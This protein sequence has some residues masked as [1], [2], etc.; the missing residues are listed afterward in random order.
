VPGRDDDDIS[1]LSSAAEPKHTMI[2]QIDEIDMST[3]TIPKSSVVNAI[4]TACLIDDDNP[5]DF[6]SPRYNVGLSPHDWIYE[7]DDEYDSFDFPQSIQSPILSSDHHQFITDNSTPTTTPRNALLA[8]ED[9]INKLGITKTEFYDNLRNIYPTLTNRASLRAHFDGGSM[10]TTTDQLC[11]LW[12][13]KDLN[14]TDPGRVLQV[15]DNHRHH[16]KGIGFLRLPT[17]SNDTC[18]VRCLYTP[19]LPAT[20]VSPHDAGIQYQ[21]SGYSCASNFD[22]TNCSIRL[23]FQP[24][25]QQRDICFSLT[26]IRGL[27]FFQTRCTADIIT[28]LRAYSINDS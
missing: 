28:T 22:G 24:E 15:A 20:I 26:L 7:T 13:Y 23:H 10:A 12:F 6:D 16:S 18:F 9:Q 11:C 2:C 25:S 3:D 21:C 27:L 8:I 1:R 5:V 19:T 14:S 4:T 17:K